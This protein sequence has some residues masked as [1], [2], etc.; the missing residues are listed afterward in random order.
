ME[1]YE[2]CTR[3]GPCAGCGRPDPRRRPGKDPRRGDPG[4]ERGNQQ[5]WRFLLV[6]DRDLIEQ[7]APLYKDSIDQ[8]WGTFYKRQGDRR[9]R[10]P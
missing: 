10:A 2:A 7:L 4:A 5:N 9:Q 3:R 1:L 8:L 6:D